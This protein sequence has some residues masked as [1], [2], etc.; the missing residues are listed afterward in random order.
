[1]AYLAAG[2]IDG[3]WEEGLAAW[4]IAAG[5]VMVKEAGGFVYEASG[6][7]NM[8]DSGSVVGGNESIQKALS[9]VIGRSAPQ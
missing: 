2:H 8:L 1:L 5:I 6:E 3:F 7:L 9:E 4:D